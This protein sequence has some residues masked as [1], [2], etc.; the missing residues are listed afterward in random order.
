VLLDLKGASPAGWVVQPEQ[1]DALEEVRGTNPSRG[2]VPRSR[3]NRSAFR[4]PTVVSQEGHPP[5]GLGNLGAR[6]RCRIAPALRSRSARRRVPRS[7]SRGGRFVH[8]RQYRIF[9]SRAPRAGRRRPGLLETARAGEARVTHADLELYALRPRH[10]DF[11]AVR[12]NP[13]RFEDPSLIAIY[14]A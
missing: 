7:S 3:E 11:S 9:A 12:S 5:R 1:P 4:P 2:S 8:G 6:C 13:P 14:G 10:H